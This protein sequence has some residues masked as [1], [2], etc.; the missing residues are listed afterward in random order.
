MIDTL[1][2]H[3]GQA[4]AMKF[5][6]TLGLRDQEYAVMTLHR[7][8]NVDDPTR[9]KSILD[10]VHQLSSRVRT[11]FVVHPRTSARLK[12]FGFGSLGDCN[13]SITL[14]PVG[15]MAMLSLMCGSRFV[16]TDSGGIQEETTALGVP[17]LTLRDNT[18]RPI[19]AE[20]GT[21]E[22]VGWQTDRIVAGAHRILEN[23]SEPR[24]LPEK[25]DGAAAPRIA[26]VLMRDPRA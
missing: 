13:G 22:L 18:E 14:E 19:T 12:E 17:C 4:R 20:I 5:H 11:V 26:D 24:R 21:N 15:Y 23:R 8:S 25:W 10:A 3:S 16:M 6:E 2:R 7:P 1:M 9:L